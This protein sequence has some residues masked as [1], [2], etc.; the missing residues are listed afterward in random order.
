[1]LIPNSYLPETVERS[2]RRPNYNP[3][4][5]DGRRGG[6]RRAGVELPFLPAGRRAEPVEPAVARSHVD[7]IPGRGRRRIDARLGRE[8]PGLLAARRVD[9]VHQLVAAADD[10]AAAGEG[11]RGVEGK[12]TFGVLVAPDDL[13]RLEIERQHLVVERADEGAIALDHRRGRRI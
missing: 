7:A 1:M 12:L 2:V 13:L 8:R 9:G 5:S 6:D 10:D 4:R 3:S 11:S